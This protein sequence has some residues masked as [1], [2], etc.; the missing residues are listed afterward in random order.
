MIES[1]LSQT[2]IN[3]FA[4]SLVNLSILFEERATDEQ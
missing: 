3:S 1:I 2:E 4:M